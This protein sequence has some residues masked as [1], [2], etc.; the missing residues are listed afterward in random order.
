MEDWVKEWA[1]G[2]LN[3]IPYTFKKLCELPSSGE[4]KTNLRS[5]EYLY[6]KEEKK[7]LYDPKLTEILQRK[8]KFH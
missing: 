1:G 5:S 4:K 3:F 2:R 7:R 8:N 6:I